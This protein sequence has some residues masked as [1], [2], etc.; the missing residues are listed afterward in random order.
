MSIS[1]DQVR[2]VA[3]LSRLE[4]QDD[5]LDRFT[6]Q[7]Q[8]ILDYASRLDALDISD[9]APTSH[10]VPVANVLR[11]DKARPSLPVAKALEQAPEPSGD[12]FTVPR[13]IDEGEGH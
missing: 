12:F 5:E 4:M 3:H 2:D 11:E 10:V 8:A 13:I 7:L 1:R 6:V 9:V